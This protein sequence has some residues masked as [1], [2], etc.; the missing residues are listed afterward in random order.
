MFKS[1]VTKSITAVTAAGLVAGLL[2]FLTSVAPE[3]KAESQPTTALDQLVAKDDR[4]ATPLMGAA[5]S[6]RS[7]P[8]YDQ[9]CQF[10]RRAAAQPAR[11]VRVIA[12]R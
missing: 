4:V 9:G 8:H 1:V 2:V 12:L 5:C 11:T 10:D 7:W 3:A 6:S